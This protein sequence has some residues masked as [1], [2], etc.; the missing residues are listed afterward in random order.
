MSMVGGGIWKSQS[1]RGDRASPRGIILFCLISPREGTPPR[2]D[3]QK[4]KE[5]S[6]L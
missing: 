2:A 1:G 5:L 6:F 3:G 4:N